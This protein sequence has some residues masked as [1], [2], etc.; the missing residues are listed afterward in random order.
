M[1]P[2]ITIVAAMDRGRVLGAQ[3]DLPWHLPKDLR[4]FKR[5]TRGKPVVMGR[6]TW[7]SIPGALPKRLNVVVTRRAGYRAEG[8]TVV[9]SL[10]AAMAAAGDVEEVMIVGGAQIY[11]LALEIADRLELTYIDATY[12]GDTFF[13][14][15]DE[16][17]WRVVAEETHEPDERHA[18]AFRFV[19][20]ER[21]GSSR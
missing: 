16:S 12:E 6:K 3:G 21:A 1:S 2:R 4:H 9:G 14:D 20:L 11:A 5:L 17:A 8:A 13:P 7:E 18:H 10:E 19:S 15:F